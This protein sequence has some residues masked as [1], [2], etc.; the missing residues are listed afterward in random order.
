MSNVPSLPPPQLPP[1]AAGA[2]NCAPGARPPMAAPVAA[3]H[4]YAPMPQRSANGLPAEV[5]A[6][7]PWGR[8]GCSMLE[9]VLMIVTLGIGW[10]IWAA[11][12]VGG[13]QTPAK[14][15]LSYRV[16]GADT[17]RPVGFG[18]MFFMRYL[19]AGFVA[20]LA[21]LF[22]VGVLLFMPFWDSR[23]QNIWDKVSSTYV[24][25]DPNDA[26]NTSPALR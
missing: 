26:W 21:I 20:N 2:P 5:R 9:G 4:Q 24:V 11:M 16:I 25:H 23:R 13:G 17:L 18:R 12:I 7:S 3:Y 10:V 19:V 22:T 1:P 14:K 6:V 8:L 15:L